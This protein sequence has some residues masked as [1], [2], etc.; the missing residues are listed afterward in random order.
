MFFLKRAQGLLFFLFLLDLLFLGAGR[1]IPVLDFSSRKFFFLMFFASS[2]LVYLGGF[3]G[4]EKINVI[5]ILAVCIF[6][7][8]WVIFIP[9]MGHG[10]LSYAVSDAM[11][12]VA[13]SVFL[14]TTQFSRW[15]NSWTRIR[16][17][18]LGF[19]YV[20]AIV[21]VILYAIFMI[22]PSLL[23]D[24]A[25]V[26]A[27]VFDVG[28][29]SEARFV[30]FTPLD[31]GGSRIYFAS[32]F[33]LLIGIYFLISNEKGIFG[34]GLHSR[35]VFVIILAG[36][37]WA[38]NTRS[39]LLG[40]LAMVILFP[41]SRWLM[42]CIRQSWLTIFL[43]LVL[44]FFLVFLLIPTVDME[45]L[46]LLGL[47]REGSDDIR[48]EQLYS[49]LN[50]FSGHW[51]FGLGFGANASIVRVEDAPY[52]Y[53]LSILALFMKIG[54]IGVLVACGIWASVLLSLLSE[55]EET[56]KKKFSSLYVLYISFIVSCFYNPY[57]FGFFGTLFLLFILYEFS[58]LARREHK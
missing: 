54:V 7:F 40:A 12:L 52:A 35:F 4:K 19:L 50:A 2:L 48:S 16:S 42:T 58:F 22:Y 55:S 11:P 43:L 46:A 30:F 29:G 23:V 45:L 28:V 27:Q 26:F 3:A 47:G 8:L 10:N 25:E 20:F 15:S 38:T 36:A 44:P 33:L 18:L 32:S 24:F 53:E 31:G 41:A 37:L 21:H 57:I 34:C 14:L 39:L 13:S 6:L 1:D 9:F 17:V 51:F 49:L 5:A 56:S